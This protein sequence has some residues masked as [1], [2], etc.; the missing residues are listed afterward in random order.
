MV[1][2]PYFNAVLSSKERWGVHGFGL[3]FEEFV[4]LVESL[5]LQELPLVGSNF[6]FSEGG[7]G[8]ACSGL[9]RFLVR[10]GTWV[11]LTEWF[12]RHCSS[13]LRII[14][15][16]WLAQGWFHWVLGC[17]SF[18]ICGVMIQSCIQWLRRCR[19][20]AGLVFRDFGVACKPLC[21]WSI[22]GKVSIFVKI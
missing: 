11:G 4:N 15:L 6:T 22:D 16:S 17:L 3:A 21:G 10:I 9:N 5:E 13:S 7:A 14:C 19:R 1:I 18:L 8:I 2:L 20:I 12:S